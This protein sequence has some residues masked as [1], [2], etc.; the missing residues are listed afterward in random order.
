MQKIGLGGGCHWCTEA[1]FQSLLGV[2]KV[3][4][5]WASSSAQYKDYSEAVIVH[6]NDQKIGLEA[7]I[8][9][10]LHTHS[11]T[12]R[13]NLRQK[14]RSAIYCLFK[15]QEKS[16]ELIIQ[17]LQVQ[18]DRPI[19]TNV[20]PL[21]RVKKNQPYYHNYYYDDPGKPFCKT[22]IQ[23]KIELIKKRFSKHLISNSGIGD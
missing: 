11:C 3:E 22:F 10:H 8:E 4:Q 15:N 21:L 2:E 17:Q 14:Y 18:F 9:I 1:V 16:A 12:S 19:I 20:L 6:F 7:L 5:G 23:P 13:H